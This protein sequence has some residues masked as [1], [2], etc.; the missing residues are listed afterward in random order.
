MPFD[1]LGGN[2]C[3]LR[4]AR[5][6]D[7]LIRLVPLAELVGGLDK[8]TLGIMHELRSGMTLIVFD[9]R[10]HPQ[11]CLV[12]LPGFFD[13]VLLHG[14]VEVTL[15]KHVAVGIESGYL[16]PYEYLVLR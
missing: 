2:I 15:I 13:T 7:T 11:E 12:D 3:S 5:D 6:V 1:R 9:R 8:A 14:D 16:Q 10:L 4:D